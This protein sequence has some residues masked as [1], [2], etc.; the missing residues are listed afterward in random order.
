MWHV[1]LGLGIIMFHFLGFQTSRDIPLFGIILT[2][3]FHSPL[4]PQPIIQ[5]LWEVGVGQEW[6]GVEGKVC[7]W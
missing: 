1:V 3:T 5:Q 6:S 2:L 4:N 7:G